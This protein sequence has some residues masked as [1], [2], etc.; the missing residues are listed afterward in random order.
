MMFTAAGDFPEAQRRALLDF[1][2]ACP[3]AEHGSDHGWNADRER[4][5]APPGT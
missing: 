4:P 2:H 3:D 5:A 1:L